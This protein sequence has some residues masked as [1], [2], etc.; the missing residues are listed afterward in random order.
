MPHTLKFK[1]SISSILYYKFIN[2]KAETLTPLHSLVRALQLSHTL[3]ARQF[4]NNNMYWYSCIAGTI[5][6]QPSLYITAYQYFYGNWLSQI[7]CFIFGLL[8]PFPSPTLPTVPLPIAWGSQY[9]NSMKADPW[10][11]S[12]WGENHESKISWKV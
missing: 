8:S 10:F 11:T 7:F 3:E 5:I 2:T 6:T 9:S 1:S 4:Y 12:T